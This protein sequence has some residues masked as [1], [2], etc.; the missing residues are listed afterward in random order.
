VLQEAAELAKNQGKNVVIFPEGVRSY[1]TSPELLPFKR[2]AVVL[3]VQAGH[4][5]IV[6]IV[7]GNF[8]RV[9]D[10]QH[11]TYSPGDVHVKVL[12]PISTVFEDGELESDAIDRILGE[13]RL[14]MLETLKEISA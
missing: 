4:I 14:S 13:L 11:G 6:P 7:I 5:P 2:G 10:F 12:V 9:F 8:S 1:A 3:A